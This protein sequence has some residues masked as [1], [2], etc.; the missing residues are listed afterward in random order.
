MRF[1]TALRFTAAVSVLVLSVASNASLVALYKLHKDARDSTKNHNDGVLENL[2]IFKH[3][4][5]VLDGSL[6]QFVTCPVNIDP[7]VMPQITMGGWF[8]FTGS[9]LPGITGIL[10]A[11]VGGYGRQLDIDFRGDSSG[12]YFWSSFA[13]RNPINAP[14][15]GSPFVPNK[16]TFVVMRAD[17][18]TGNLTLT[19]DKT[20]YVRQG[21]FFTPNL[22]TL[23]I[24]RNPYYDYPF[25]GL[26][27]NVFIYNN[28]LS[29]KALAELRNDTNPDEDDQG[30]DE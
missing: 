20:N 5:L 23:A 14:L 9:S 1:A 19:V 26:V 28:V 2:P 11:D 4:S 15:A 6:N 21:V 24:G 22:N 27:Q 16:W 30:E 7:S 12:N 13:S 25:T 29:D 18:A 3:G 17:Q 8:K 10:G